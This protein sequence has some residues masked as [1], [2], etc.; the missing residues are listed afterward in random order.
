MFYS[1][2]GADLLLITADYS[3]S[4]NE[5][6]QFLNTNYYTNGSSRV[7]SSLWNLTTQVSTICIALNIVS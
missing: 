1:S 3:A 6:L 5:I 2:G 7:F 4:A